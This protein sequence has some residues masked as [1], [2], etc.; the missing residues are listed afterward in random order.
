MGGFTTL[1][2]APKWTT[3]MVNRSAGYEAPLIY[4]TQFLDARI[5]F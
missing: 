4:P 3:P 2:I 1:I 5:N